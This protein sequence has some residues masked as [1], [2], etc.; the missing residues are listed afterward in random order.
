M[1]GSI[2]LLARFCRSEPVGTGHRHTNRKH[3]KSPP[4]LSGWSCIRHIRERTD[5]SHWALKF[6]PRGRIRGTWPAILRLF[7]LLS[8]RQRCLCLDAVSSVCTPAG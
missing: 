3:S 1:F 4:E 7:P 5:S 6:L 2:I 8:S